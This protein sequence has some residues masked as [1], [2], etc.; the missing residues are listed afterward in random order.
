MS[1]LHLGS[2]FSNITSAALY[3]CGTIDSVCL[4][5]GAVDNGSGGP[6]EQAPGDTIKDDAAQTPAEPAPFR[7]PV[8]AE[9]ATPAQHA[10][11][12]TPATDEHNGSISAEP[13]LFMPPIYTE[14]IAGT[15]A[16]DSPP[17][18]PLVTPQGKPK[19]GTN[20]PGADPSHMAST[21]DTEE[22]LGAETHPVHPHAD[23]EEDAGASLTAS[24][25]SPTPFTFPTIL[26]QGARTHPSTPPLAALEKEGSVFPVDVQEELGSSIARSA[27]SCHPPSPPATAVQKYVSTASMDDDDAFA[28]WL[29]CGKHALSFLRIPI[30]A[31][32]CLILKRI[33]FLRQAVCPVQ[34]GVPRA[35]CI[36]HSTTLCSPA[37]DHHHVQLGLSID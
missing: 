17:V 32:V 36:D 21:V 11:T 25:P 37:R 3:C 8:I 16:P 12:A 5:A 31:Q 10:P 14:E 9:D 26:E 24:F 7:R 15:E 30:T 19:E 27:P 28:E 22:T 29:E 2:A 18:T 6:K 4:S 13:S 35:L 20:A 33:V 1:T 34:Q 23:A